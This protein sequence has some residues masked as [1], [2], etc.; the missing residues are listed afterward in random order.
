LIW[1]LAVS[2]AMSVEELDATVRAFYES[3]GDV[4]SDTLAVL[5]YSSFLN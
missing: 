2:M 1:L 4:V 3:R 5:C